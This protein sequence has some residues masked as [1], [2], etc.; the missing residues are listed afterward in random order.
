VRWRPSK[1]SAAAGKSSR[2]GLVKKEKADIPRYVTRKALDD[3][4]Y[5][6]IGEEEKKTRRDPVGTGAVIRKQV[7]VA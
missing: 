5:L 6:M 3:G 2:I 7:S 1:D 4:L